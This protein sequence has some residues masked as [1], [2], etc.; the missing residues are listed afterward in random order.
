MINL[1]SRRALCRHHYCHAIA[2]THDERY[3]RTQCWS[4]GINGPQ[5]ECHNIS[6]D[7]PRQMKWRWSEKR[8]KKKYYV[9]FKCRLV[10]I[11]IVFWL[12]WN[13]AH[14]LFFFPAAS[15]MRHQSQCDGEKKIVPR[16]RAWG[17]MGRCGMKQISAH[18]L[19]CE[20]DRILNGRRFYKPKSLIVL[21]DEVK[22]WISVLWLCWCECFEWSFFLII[23]KKLLWIGLASGVANKSFN[24]IA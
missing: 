19:R 5:W 24:T 4:H 13:L 16:V 23:C 6:R 14:M 12:R 2:I 10:G 3:E 17:K 8:K 7:K 1:H 18:M 11:I 9:K 21:L 22:E 15:L 20:C